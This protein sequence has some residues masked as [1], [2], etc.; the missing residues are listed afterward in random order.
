MRG[1]R[2]KWVL[3]LW[4]VSKR[5]IRKRG[6]G[7][8]GEDRGVKAGETQNERLGRGEIKTDKGCTGVSRVKIS[9]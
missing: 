4:R 7:S 2:L 1:A 5:L 8:F 9:V 3:N 6:Y